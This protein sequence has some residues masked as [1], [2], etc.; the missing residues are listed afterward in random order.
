[1]IY[2]HNRKETR[3]EQMMIDLLHPYMERGELGMKTGKGFYSYPNPDY[4]QA[5]FLGIDI[6]SQFGRAI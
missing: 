3:S 5:D 1:M 4:Q 6:M 2:L